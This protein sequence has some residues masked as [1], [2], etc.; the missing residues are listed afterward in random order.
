MAFQA[1][2]E[3][4]VWGNPPRRHSAARPASGVIREHVR[5]EGLKVAWARPSPRVPREEPIREGQLD[6]SADPSSIRCAYLDSVQLGEWWP[7]RRDTCTMF[8]PSS[9]R[10]LANA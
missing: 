2:A 8:R 5:A 9:M 6:R 3:P 7:S 10:M 1:D 4:V